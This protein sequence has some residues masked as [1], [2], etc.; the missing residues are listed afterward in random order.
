MVFINAIDQDKYA[1]SFD[2]ISVLVL[3]QILTRWHMRKK[4][5]RKAFL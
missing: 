4:Q 5:K 3:A 1:D 2:S